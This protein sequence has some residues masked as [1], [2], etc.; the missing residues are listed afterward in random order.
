MATLF[1]TNKNNILS[2]CNTTQQ[3]ISSESECN[4]NETFSSK[5]TSAMYQTCTETKGKLLMI[6]INVNIQELVKSIQKVSQ[7]HQWNEQKSEK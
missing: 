2:Y 3:N 4:E 7:Y 6:Q 5:F 1:H